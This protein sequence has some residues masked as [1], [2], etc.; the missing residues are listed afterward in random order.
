M[1]NRDFELDLDMDLDTSVDMSREEYR[2]QMEDNYR[3]SLIE[4]SNREFAE[5]PPLYAVD[6][7]SLAEFMVAVEEIESESQE[8]YDEMDASLWSKED[9]EFVHKKL[10]TIIERAK[11]LKDANDEL[12]EKAKIS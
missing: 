7:D 12:K 3:Q 2:L 6:T 8:L 1:G 9:F 11:E 5:A 4:D 10:D